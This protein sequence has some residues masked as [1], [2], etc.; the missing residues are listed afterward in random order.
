[1]ATVDAESPTV[2]DGVNEIKHMF[3]HLSLHP[4]WITNRPTIAVNKLLQISYDGSS[5]HGSAIYRVTED[6]AEWEMT[7][8]YKADVDKMKT[9]LF[10]ELQHTTTFLHLNKENK[11]YNALLIP[12]FDHTN[13]GD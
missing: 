12:Y 4:A 2:Y 5:W 8:N 9:V 7:F 10:T 13:I 3:I 6:G 1:M 11:G